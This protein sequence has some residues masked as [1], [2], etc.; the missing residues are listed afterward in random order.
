MKDFSGTAQAV[1][2]ITESKIMQGKMIQRSSSH[3][4]ATNH[5]AHT[6]GRVWLEGADSFRYADAQRAARTRASR[7]GDPLGLRLHEDFTVANNPG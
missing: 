6:S 7:R 3:H 2:F 4:F 5:F 1:R